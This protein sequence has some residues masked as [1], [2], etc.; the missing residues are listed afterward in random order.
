MYAHSAREEVTSEYQYKRNEIH[1]HA[2]PNSVRE[3]HTLHASS[4]NRESANLNV[5]VLASRSLFFF[6]LDFC[7]NFYSHNIYIC[8]SQAHAD[9]IDRPNERM[10]ERN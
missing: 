7:M 6:S 4:D 10:K 2:V 3:T 5:V 8:F 9:T 1:T